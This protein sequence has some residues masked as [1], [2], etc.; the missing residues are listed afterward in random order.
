MIWRRGTIYVPIVI[1]IWIAQNVDLYAVSWWT[2]ND[3][4]G[5]YRLANR[6]GA[7]L[8]YFTAAMFMAWTPLRGTSTFR[9]GGRGARPD[10]A[11]R[12]LLTYFLLAGLLLVLLMTVAADTLVRIAP[13]AYAA[14][15]PLI[16]LMGRPSS[17]MGSTSPSTDSHPFRRR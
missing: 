7:F 8:D 13:P 14:A 2:N 6:L 12:K 5:L 16:P 9:G 11:R 4:V 10:G 3:Q 1:S 15:A 17:L